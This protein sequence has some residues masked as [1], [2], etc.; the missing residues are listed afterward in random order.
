ME[1]R[2]KAG[3]DVTLVIDDIERQK[4]ESLG[5]VGEHAQERVFRAMARVVADLTSGSNID[6]TPASRSNLLAPGAVPRPTDR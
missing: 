3:P 6:W 1:N 4:W 2:F 5:I